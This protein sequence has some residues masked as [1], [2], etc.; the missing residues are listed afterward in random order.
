MQ[1]PRIQAELTPASLADWEGE[2]PYLN[3]CKLCNDNATKAWLHHPTIENSRVEH[4]DFTALQ[5]ERFEASDVVFHNCDF[6]NV[7]LSEATL[8]RVRFDQC[9][10]VG[11]NLTRCYAA[12]VQFNECQM[13]LAWLPEATLK[14]VSFKDCRLERAE[15]SEVHATKLGFDHCMIDGLGLFGTRLLGI[16][17]ATC[18]F[19]TI[20]ANATQ[21]R[22]LHVTSEQAAALAARYLGLAVSD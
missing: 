20:E 18:D 14:T 2:D 19:T 22:G 9:R 8:Y 15:L 1:E 10:L 3:G 5:A 11:T 21:L 6:A 4:V 13:T 17:V 16:D 12:N 7:D